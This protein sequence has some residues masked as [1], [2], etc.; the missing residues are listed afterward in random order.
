MNPIIKKLLLTFISTLS[1]G[2]TN[3]TGVLSDEVCQ[4]NV[5]KANSPASVSFALIHLLTKF[6]ES[7]IKSLFFNKF[8]VNKL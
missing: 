6:K 2:C 4:N 8:I 7:K 5:S 3:R 1:I